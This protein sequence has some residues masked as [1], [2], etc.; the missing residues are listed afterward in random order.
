MITL[1]VDLTKLKKNVFN[2]NFFT[3]KPFVVLLNIHW[4]LKNISDFT[5][6]SRLMKVPLIY[7]TKTHLLSTIVVNGIP[8][9]YEIAKND[10][11]FDKL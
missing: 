8:S 7:L 3:K 6:D 11:Q 10:D 4:I 2:L 1:N 5:G 9:A